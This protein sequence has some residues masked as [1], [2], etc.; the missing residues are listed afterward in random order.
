MHIFFLIASQNVII[1]KKWS[2][3]V[4]VLAVKKGPKVPFFEVA[5]CWMPCSYLVYIDRLLYQL[6]WVGFLI[7]FL[8]FIGYVDCLFWKWCSYLVLIYL[9]LWKNKIEADLLTSEGLKENQ[10]NFFLIKKLFFMNIKGIKKNW[11]FNFF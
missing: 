8:L 11:K 7:I 4:P 3:K 2:L 10:A 6:I 5:W 1:F 9:V